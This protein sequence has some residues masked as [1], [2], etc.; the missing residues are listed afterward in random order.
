[1][2]TKGEKIKIF[3]M[4]AKSERKCSCCCSPVPSKRD[5]PICP[6]CG[7]KGSSVKPVT[8]KSLLREEK[9]KEIKIFEDFFFC[10]NPHCHVVY[11]RNGGNPVIL[12][13]DLKVRVGIKEKDDPIPVCYCFGW[14]RDKIWKEIQEKGKSSAVEEILARCK[15]GESACEI[16]NP[17]GRCCL[18]HV[19]K[20]I[21]EGMAI[22]KKSDTSY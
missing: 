18:P 14:T 7:K 3:N 4:S 9:L 12:K 6:L 2:L 13:N 20:V 19:K 21:K 10:G 11:F 8:I 15:A 17:S 1:M 5:E 22:F 16:N